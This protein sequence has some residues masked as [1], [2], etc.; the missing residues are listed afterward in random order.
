[1][2]Q[3]A[4]TQLPPATSGR[5]ASLD[6][7]RG[8]TIVAMLFVNNPGWPEAFP[9]Q[10]RHAAW[11]E[12]VT[13]CDMI[14]PWFLFIV[15]V[16]I[17]FSTASFLK[18]HPDAGLG[19]FA[20]RC[21]KRAAIL[22]F[23]GILI[24]T[25]VNKRIT[26]GMNVLQLIGL[27]FFAGAM[28]Y[29]AP[30]KIRYAVAAGLLVFYWILLRFVPVPGEGEWAFEQNRNIIWWFNNQLRPFYLA[31]ILSVIPTAALVL[32]GTWFGDRFRETNV[33]GRPQ[34]L[35]KLLVG[36][37][38]LTA[39]GLLWHL[40][41][42]MSKFVWSPSYILFSAGL[43][44]IL[45]GAFFWAMDIKGWQRW[46][47]LFVVYG[48]NAIFAYF[49][50]IIVRLNTVQ[51]WYTTLE[52]GEEVTLWRA[53]LLF[54]TDLAGRNLGSWL[55]TGSYILFWFFVLLWMYR[56]KLFWRV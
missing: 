10:M 47:F 32:I 11:G 7:F 29:R 17:P 54:W 26:I 36:G 37:A 42:E 39:A 23:L 18:R 49:V 12:F 24:D 14:F 48:M 27:A 55:F 34:M 16:A 31:G 30:A 45:L 6:A 35:K 1:M 50:S 44:A 53:M 4:A 51:A 38:I 3:P 28:L 20:W 43:G 2:S 13:F 9:D 33:E 15:G 21:A 41:L 5:L 19:T 22:V 52:T 8:F 40:N 25:S 56:R 46:A